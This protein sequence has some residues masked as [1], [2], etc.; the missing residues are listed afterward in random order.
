MPIQEFSNK[1][2]MPKFTKFK[3]LVLSEFHIFDSKFKNYFSTAMINCFYIISPGKKEFL[4]S[5]CEII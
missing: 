4:F 1:L 5:F 3:T 2:V